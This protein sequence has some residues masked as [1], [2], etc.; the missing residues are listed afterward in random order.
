MGEIVKGGALRR[1][2]INLLNAVLIKLPPLRERKEDICLLI[3]HFLDKFNTKRE[4]KVM[5]MSP[6]TLDVAA[7]QTGLEIKTTDWTSK[8]GGSGI[9]AFPNVTAAA[10][11]EDVLEVRNNSQVLELSPS[12][13][14]VVRVTE[15]K[16]S[17]Q[18]PLEKIKD[19]IRAQIQRDKAAEQ[20]KEEGETM[21]ADVRAL[22]EL[23]E[24][25]VV[26]ASL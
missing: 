4:N 22:I 15:H 7:E 26:E 23:A 25:Q 11:S 3:N 9:A 21:L 18:I 20:V 19:P 17:E 1:G 8:S 2:F 5:N 10:F 6:D 24:Q 16:P 14:V 13:V 12:R